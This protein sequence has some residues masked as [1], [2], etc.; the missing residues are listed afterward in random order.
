FKIEITGDG[1]PTIRLAT[2][3]GYGESM[4]N[5]RGALSETL[6]IYQL[7]IAKALEW[8]LPEVR[9]FSMGLGLGYNEL[10]I[11]AHCLMKGLP[12]WKLVSYESVEFLRLAFSGWIT[13]SLPNNDLSA[14]LYALYDLVLSQMARELD[15]TNPDDLRSLLE[16]KLT[17][18]D[19][20]IEKAYRQETRPPF[21]SQVILYDAFS[22]NSS[23]DLWSEQN[24]HLVINSAAAQACA[25]STYA[26]TGALKRV[27]A[28][29]QFVIE[30]TS[31]FGGK[32]QST[33]AY[34]EPK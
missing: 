1:S 18:G 19:W 28:A 29:N 23:P 9:F 14:K 6:Y 34:R 33:F 13:R 22:S 32:R 15:L 3:E 26:A 30:K 7:P 25:F 21:S 11:T 27:L 4:H 31:G 17:D 8:N 10:L 20:R 2:P 24:L 5:L 16:K 12:H